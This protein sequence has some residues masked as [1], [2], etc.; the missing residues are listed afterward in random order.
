MALQ[1]RGS[2]RITGVQYSLLGGRLAIDFANSS[3]IPGMVGDSILEWRDL[4]G[5][6]FAVGSVS[7]ERRAALA[8]LANTAPEET[9]VVLKMALAMRGALQEILSARASSKPIHTDLVAPINAVLRHT[10][11]H[12]WLERAEGPGAKDW[13]L[14]LRARSQGLEWLLAAIARSAAELIAE[15]PSAP[16]HRC[17]SPQCALFFYD[18]S[19]TGK[20]R[21]CSMATCGNRAKV[22]AHFQ[23]LRAGKR[24]R[25]RIT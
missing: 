17:A 16:I 24:S 20:R 22:A 25:P 21:W 13:R 19:R 23:R 5:F 18:G 3:H 14:T 15:G 6:F 11:G 9:A 8:E 4:V 7:P 10:E 12:D 1:S 2:A